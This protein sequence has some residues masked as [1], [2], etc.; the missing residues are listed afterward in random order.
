MTIK[1]SRT[2]Q[3]G[4]LLIEQGLLSPEQLQKALDMQVQ[5]G[6]LLG[7]IIVK[8]G[9]V[10]QEQMDECLHDQGNR[11]QNI[12]TVL[13]EIGILTMEQVD[14]L[15][16]QQRLKGGSITQL[17]IEQQYLS[18]TDIV[19][20]LVTQYGFPFLELGNYE[21]DAAIVKLVP[22]DV[23]E[24]YRLIAIDKIGTILTIAIADPLNPAAFEEVRK[25]TGLEVE[26]F[27]ATFSDISNAIGQ[28][29]S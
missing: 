7:Q 25:H 1:K 2:K 9:F 23:A 6:G 3:V 29:Y 24:K 16:L 26:A 18:E 20:A 8:L 5:E 19:S 21:I 28:H 12:E 4:Q 13:Y 17:I 15:R 14:Q 10:S 22:K 27:I 11:P